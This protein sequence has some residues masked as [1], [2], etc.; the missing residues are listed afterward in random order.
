[1]PAKKAAAKKAPAK[2][3]KSGAKDLKTKKT[4]KGGPAFMKLGDIKGESR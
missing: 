2:A 1:M 3:S 4:V